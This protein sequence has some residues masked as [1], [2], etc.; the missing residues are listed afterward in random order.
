M[1]HHSNVSLL[2]IILEYFIGGWGD[3]ILSFAAKMI[4]I[5]NDA[6]KKA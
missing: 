1:L 3:G 6:E 2:F 4:E 5:F